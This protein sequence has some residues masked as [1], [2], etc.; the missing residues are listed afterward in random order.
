M[1][2]EAP[3]GLGKTALLEHAA[4]RATQA[5][6][7]VRRAAP[8][9]LERHFPFG[10]VRTLLEAPLRDASSHERARLLEGAAAS[11]GALLL[12]GTVPDD[13][14][15]MMIAHS[16][17]WLCSA[18]ADERP[19][20]LVIDDAHWADRPSLEVLAYLARRIA[21]LPLLIV[22]A[23]RADDPDAASDLL[24]QIGGD[25]PGDAAA[26]AAADAPRARSS[27]SSAGARH[28]GRGLPRL[29]SGGAGNPWLLGELG[30]QIAVHGPA[31]I[32]P[33]AR[34]RPA[35]H[36]SRAT[37]SAGASPS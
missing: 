32:D 8:G 23:A 37:S 3:A 17:L 16:V 29:P 34:T 33:P 21:D 1:V 18:M 2:L 27:S 19:L 6:C 22:L 30:Q 36:A 9:P 28:A 5:G 26:P 24:S 20:A 11:A 25:A 15:T 4:R 14:G 35:D 31:A 7:L 13:D 12:D 10:V